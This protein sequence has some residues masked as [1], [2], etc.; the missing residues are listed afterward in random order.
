MSPAEAAPR[1][2]REVS[3]EGRGGL[4]S[5]GAECDGTAGGEQHVGRAW[6]GEVHKAVSPR[7]WRAQQDSVPLR[8]AP[9]KSSKVSWAGIDRLSFAR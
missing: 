5:T 7:D 9:G 2:F 3:G 1:G 6:R 8:V 4:I